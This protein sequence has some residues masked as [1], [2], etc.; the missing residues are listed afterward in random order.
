MKYK[1][2]FRS[3]KILLPFA[4]I[5]FA[6]CMAD[7]AIPANTPSPSITTQIP[8]TQTKTP[9]IKATKVVIPTT[10][11]Q[12][13]TS[14]PTRKPNP[15]GTLIPGTPMGDGVLTKGIG[16]HRAEVMGSFDGNLLAWVTKDH[17]GR[18]V[19]VYAGVDIPDE[20]Q[21]KLYVVREGTI[22]EGFGDLILLPNR[23]GRPEIIDAIG[24]RLII[25]TE[26]GDT[27][28]FDVPSGKIAPNLT[29]TLATMTPGPTITPRV[30]STPRSGDDVEDS[31]WGINPRPLNE[32]LTYF[33]NPKGDEDWF[34]FYLPAKTNVS[35]TLSNLPAPYGLKVY[36][37]YDLVEIKKNLE[38]STADKKILISNAES[39]PYYVRVFG[40]SDAYHSSEPYT[41]RFSTE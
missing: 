36:Y 30:T 26:G 9:T 11:A 10:I 40:I 32:E 4:I 25:K 22:W 2:H 23:S 15:T 16:M 37:T 13:T 19:I 12:P 3:I 21:G 34:H 29:A 8:P 14:S 20:Q 18:S 27:F 41:L 33:I 5:L 39:G 24:K 31:E 35:I 28:Y 38:P 6:G 7:Y 17:M 1:W